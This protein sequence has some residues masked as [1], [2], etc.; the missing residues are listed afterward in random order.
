MIP[1]HSVA[2]V[3]VCDIQPAFRVE[4]GEEHIQLARKEL[5]K[6]PGLLSCTSHKSRDHFLGAHA[7]MMRNASY[8]WKQLSERSACVPPA[9]QGTHRSRLLIAYAT[10]CLWH[11]AGK[12]SQSCSK[13]AHGLS[14]RPHQLCICKGD[15]HPLRANS[16]VCGFDGQLSWEFS[17]KIKAEQYLIHLQWT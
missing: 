14:K 1:P 11:L 4:D 2:R 17:K 13:E 5:L 10:A 8:A 9:T 16:L 3:Y 6:L 15:L 7:G 12:G